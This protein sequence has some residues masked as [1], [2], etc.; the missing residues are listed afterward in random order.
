MSDELDPTL[1]AVAE[2]V[3]DG[4]EVDW[5]GIRERAPHLA[6]ELDRMRALAEIE[7][8]YREVRTTPPEDGGP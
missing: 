6:E 1:L 2:A 4:F 7:A 3:A 8:A 5:Q